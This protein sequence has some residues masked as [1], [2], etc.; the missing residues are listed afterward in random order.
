MASYE[1]YLQRQNNINAILEELRSMGPKTRRELCKVLSLSWGCVSELITLLMERSVIIEEKGELLLEKGRIPYVIRLNE[2]KLFLGVDVNKMG[3]TICV[4]NLRGEKVGEQ[5]A[6]IHCDTKEALY[7]SVTGAI[8]SVFEN[9]KENYLGIGVAMQGVFDDK[10]N[11][12][13]FPGD[14]GGL[15]VSFKEK[16]EES[17]ELPVIVEHD[18]NCILFGEFEP[19]S[20]KSIMMVRV[21]KGIGAS[22][23]TG[24]NFLNYGKLELGY[25]VVEGKRLHDVA[26]ID[27]IEKISGASIDTLTDD[28]YFKNAGKNLGI[29]LGNFCNLISV[30]EIILSGQ[31]MKYSHLFLGDLEKTYNNTVI[32][33]LR[34]DV[35]VVDTTDAAFG[36]A[37]LAVSRYPCYKR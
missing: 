5:K 6:E 14:N 13:T 34:A 29:A 19:E 28:K 20:D 15:K 10:E 12:W 11:V 22:V 33:S 36:A 18:P 32:Q 27:G 37:K 16:L 35:R 8:N 24:G 25:M 2:K 23:Y 26:S 4:C 9:G 7:N 17:F 30:D 21:D 31:L 3:I 1:Q